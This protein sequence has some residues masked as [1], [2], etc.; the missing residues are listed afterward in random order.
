MYRESFLGVKR[1][2]RVLP[3]YIG[4]RKV[5]A[6]T[7]RRSADKGSIRCYEDG[8]DSFLV[9]LPPGQ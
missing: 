4:E 3:E 2:G 8:P 5:N 7:Q 6:D 9:R 1:R